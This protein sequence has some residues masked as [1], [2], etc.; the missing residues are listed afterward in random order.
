M[1][2]AVADFDY[3]AHLFPGAGVRGLVVEVCVVQGWREARLLWRKWTV[4]A[5]VVEKEDGRDEC[6]CPCKWGY[7][8]PFYRRLK[9]FV[10][11]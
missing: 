8:D 5:F 10:G 1:A 7:E 6:G 11:P 3:V 2:A 9:V 4:E